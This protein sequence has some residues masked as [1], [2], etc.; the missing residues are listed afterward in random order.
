MQWNGLFRCKYGG[1]SMKTETTTL[2]KFPNGGKTIVEQILALEVR[3]KSKRVRPWESQA[4]I[5]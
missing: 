3:N 1:K 4:G 5:Q 2:S